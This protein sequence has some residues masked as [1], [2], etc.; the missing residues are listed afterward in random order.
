MKAAI[1]DP[2][3]DTLGGGERYAMTFVQVLAENG[4]DVD[5]EWGDILITQKLEERLGLHLRGVNVVSSI[6]RGRGYDFCFWLSDGSIPNLFAKKNILHFQVPFHGVNGKS[7]INRLKLRK[8]NKVVCNSKF[9]KKSIDNEYGVNSLVIYPPVGVDEFNP[10]KK[11]NVILFV[12]RFSQLLQVKHQDV[13]IEA[14]KKMVDGSVVGWKLVL[15][16]GSDVGGKELVRSLKAEARGYQIEVLENPN[17][18]Q[19]KQLYGKAK[20]F[21]SASGYGIDEDKEPEKV[22]HFGITVVEAMSAGCIPVVVNKGG[23]KEIIDDSVDGILWDNV[24]DLLSATTALIN[25]GDKL[26]AVAANSRKK[27]ERF[28]KKRFENEIIKLVS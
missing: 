9:T 27:A 26:K 15:A 17:F 24:S 2:Y 4:W 6:D 7:L 13:L 20:I 18:N 25:G 23:H 12:G 8:V 10:G 11:E 1:F 22:E 14:F 21:W 5:V 3:L 19:V 16:G 28:S